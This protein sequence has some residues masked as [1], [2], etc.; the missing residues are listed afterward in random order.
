MICLGCVKDRSVRDS[1]LAAAGGVD[2]ILRVC[3]SSIGRCGTADLQLFSTTLRLIGVLIVISVVSPAIRR[4]CE[5]A[6]SS[7]KRQGVHATRALKCTMPLF[8]YPKKCSYSA[9]DKRVQFLAEHL[10]GGIES[11]AILRK[12]TEST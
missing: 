6:V 7:V 9:K 12:F 3:S 1:V 8:V 5:T 4:I 10:Q 2:K 11:L